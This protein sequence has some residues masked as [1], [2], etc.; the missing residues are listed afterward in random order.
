MPDLVLPIVAAVAVLVVLLLVV[1]RR[2]GSP[3]AAQFLTAADRRGWQRIPPAE[4]AEQVEP[5]G[6]YLDGDGSLDLAVGGDVDEGRALV[7]AVGVRDRV[8]RGRPW[9][10]AAVTRDDLAIPTIV[11]EPRSVRTVRVVAGEDEVVIDDARISRGW[12]IT[13]PDPDAARVLDAPEVRRRLSDALHRPM[14]FIVGLRL[15]PG[16]VAVH[17]AGP[18]DAPTDADDVDRL[19]RLALDVADA[20]AAAPV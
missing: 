13:S 6:R 10:V 4:A 3:L 8:A 18:E 5:F 9:F 16:G 12:R 19:A 2:G 20:L 14:P 17:L 1:R 7:A 15:R 11:M